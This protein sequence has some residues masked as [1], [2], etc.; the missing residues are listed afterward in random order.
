[1]REGGAPVSN[2][3]VRGLCVSQGVPDLWA[4]EN[5]SDLAS[6]ARAICRKCPVRLTCG[7]WA[8]TQGEKHVVA[9]GYRLWVAEDRRELQRELPHIAAPSVGGLYRS[10]MCAE[11]GR[12]FLTRHAAVDCGHC[13]A[14]FADAAPVRARLIELLRVMTT[15]EVVA[16]AGVPADALS[17]ILDPRKPSKWVSSVTAKRIS[18]LEVPE[19]AS[20]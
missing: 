5:K 19:V 15:A 13:R 2:W 6:D 3:R 11:C 9:A 7:E 20:R 1:M 10:V 12:E 17:R 16:R 4:P 14:G 18:A 8:L